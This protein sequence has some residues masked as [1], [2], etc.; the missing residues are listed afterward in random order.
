M[1]ENELFPA[2]ALQQRQCV[3]AVG[4]RTYSSGMISMFVSDIL[5]IPAGCIQICNGCICTPL[6]PYGP[7]RNRDK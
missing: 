7:A 2:T 4:C 6:P 3:D 1:F 5:Q